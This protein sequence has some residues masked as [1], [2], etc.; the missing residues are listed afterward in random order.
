MIYPASI[1]CELALEYESV[2][3]QH[4]ITTAHEH[5]DMPLLIDM[6]GDD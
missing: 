6:E 4:L 1:S 5:A 2:D 3:E